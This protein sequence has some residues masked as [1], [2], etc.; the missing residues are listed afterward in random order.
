MLERLYGRG[1]SRTRARDNKHEAFQRH[2]L[3]KVHSNFNNEFNAWWLAQRLYMK[4]IGRPFTKKM[5]DFALECLK[6]H[7]ASH[8]SFKNTFDR[9]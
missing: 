6:T 4:Y 3:Y 1:V 2:K 8:Y 9:Q 7:S 5:G